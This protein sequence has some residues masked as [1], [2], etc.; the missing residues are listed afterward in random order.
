MSNIKIAP[1]ILGVDFAKLGA[2][3]ESVNN[4]DYIHVDIM[5]GLFVPNISI[6]IP[7]VESLKKATDIPLDVHLMIDRPERYVER[8]VKA[9]ADILT[10]HVESTD[11]V[12]ECI[13]AIKQAGAIPAISI[14]PKTPF[15]QA[16]PFIEDVGLILVMTVEPGFGGQKM[17][18]ECLDKCKKLKE[19]ITEKGLD[20]LIEVDGGVTAENLNEVKE[21][22]VDIA[23]V[24]SALFKCSD[25]V[26][27]IERLRS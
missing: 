27:E 6:G 23:V 18:K 24:G 3:I 11:K 12:K 26:A 13:A 20:V 25:R 4:A 7:V 8:F 16:L 14:K 9:G 2:E 5:D 10:V 21:S 17:I 1:S 22:G 19:I 15:E